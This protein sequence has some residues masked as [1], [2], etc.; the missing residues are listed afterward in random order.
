MAFDLVLYTDGVLTTT[1]VSVDTGAETGLYAID[2]NLEILS[3]VP[4]TGRVIVSIL[5][6]GD[7]IARETYTFTGAADTIDHST[8]TQWLVT[9]PTSFSVSVTNLTTS[10]I[11]ISAVPQFTPHLSVVRVQEP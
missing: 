4:A 3:I 11:T 2:V 8:S 9:V 5:A 7:I 10:T 1:G 6:N